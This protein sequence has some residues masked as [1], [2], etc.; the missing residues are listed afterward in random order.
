[1]RLDPTQVHLA[2]AITP[3]SFKSY[4]NYPGKYP[5]SGLTFGFV[6]GMPIETLLLKCFF[7]LFFQ[8][9]ARGR[10]GTDH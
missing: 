2:L 4:C 8:T 7:P 3:Q 9:P 6:R 10:H 5:R 1:M